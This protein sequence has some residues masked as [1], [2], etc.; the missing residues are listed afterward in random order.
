MYVKLLYSLQITRHTNK[1]LCIILAVELEK[2]TILYM[3]VSVVV[4]TLAILLIVC[5]PLPCLYKVMFVM[6]HDSTVAICL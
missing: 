5:I 2:N 6:L 3:D 4:V 1:L